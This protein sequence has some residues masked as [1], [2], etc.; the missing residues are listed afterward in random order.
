MPD[1]NK[2]EDD[3]ISGIMLDDNDG[4]GLN[5]GNEGG[6]G[7]EGNEGNGG[8]GGGDQFI[9]ENG[10]EGNEGS[11]GDGNEGSQGGNENGGDTPPDPN[12]KAKPAAEG[13]KAGDEE[14]KGNEFYWRGRYY[15]EKGIL[16]ADAKL[17]HEMTDLELEDL[18]E[19]ALAEKVEARFKAKYS[20]QLEARGINPT[21]FFSDDQYYDRLFQQQYETIGKTTYDELLEKTDLDVS[22]AIKKLGAEFYISR[23][24]NQLD[25]EEVSAL[26][27]KDFVANSEEDLFEKY[28]KYFADQAKKLESKL[29]TDSQTKA[30][31][32]TAKAESDAAIVKQTLESGEIGGKKYTPDEITKIQNAMFKKDQVY[33]SPD[34]TRRRVTM[35]EKL[36]LEA[37]HDI[38][39]QLQFAANMILGIN[40]ETIKDKSERA[41]ALNMLN[42]IANAQG[43]NIHNQNK[44][45]NPSEKKD[46]VYS[47]IFLSNE[48]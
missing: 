10:G 33:T 17:D 32:A 43:V 45:N 39:K 41:G 2:L 29:K 4:D 48:A 26:V 34:G 30:Q 36:R 44:K 15:Q 28:R 5:F 13:G 25:E 9:N 19:N 8:A 46:P 40:E 14:E 20:D 47:D 22:D 18:Y 37:T 11:G 38:K 16:P 23:S 24:G 3:F 31:K 7:N 27:D 42:R 6:E 35:F 21:E 1:P 12:A